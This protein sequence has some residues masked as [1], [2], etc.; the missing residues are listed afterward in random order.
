MNEPI[1][2]GIPANNP[3]FIIAQPPSV[4]KP[5]VDALEP[6]YVKPIVELKDPKTNEKHRCEVN[7]IWTFGIFD[8]DNVPQMCLLA[9]GLDAPK[10]RNVLM[11]RYPE[12]E[13]TQQVRFIIL[14]KLD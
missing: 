6:G 4:I 3:Y 7:G 14:K 12:I 2:H 1:S 13:K 11:K 10:L 5:T 9:Y 8:L